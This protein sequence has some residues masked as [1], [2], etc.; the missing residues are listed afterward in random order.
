MSYRYDNRSGLETCCR[1]VETRRTLVNGALWRVWPTPPA[2]YVQLDRR[3]LQG[4]VVFVSPLDKWML[5]LLEA[6]CTEVRSLGRR[7]VAGS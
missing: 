1:A 2:P 6:I 4:Q 5:M 3:E 7:A